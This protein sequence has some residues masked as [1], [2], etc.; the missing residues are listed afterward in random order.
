L[1]FRVGLFHEDGEVQTRRAAADDVDPHFQR[2][3]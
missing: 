1:M 3:T 2:T